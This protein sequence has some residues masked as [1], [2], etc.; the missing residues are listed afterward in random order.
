MISVIQ[1][2]AILVMIGGV[3]KV[4]TSVFFMFIFFVFLMLSDLKSTG[5]KEDVFVAT[6]NNES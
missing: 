2:A 1:I 4:I 6:E 5:F 3:R